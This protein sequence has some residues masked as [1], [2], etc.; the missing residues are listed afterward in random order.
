MRLQGRTAIVTGAG[1]G[2]GRAI[3]LRFAAEGA[4]VVVA[5]LVDAQGTAEDI[6]AKGL[7]ATFLRV[8]ISDEA[9]VA[10]LVAKTIERYGA[11]DILIN[12]AA[13]ASTLRPSPFEQQS[14]ADWRK[15]LDVNVLGLFLMCRAVSPH[16]RARKYGR[17]VNFSSGT[18]L[19]GAPGMMHYV[20]SKGAIGAMTLSLA[21]ELGADE[22]TVNAIAPGYL[23]SEGNLANDSTSGALREILA[24]RRAIQR[25]G[26]PEDVVSTALY[27]A[28]EDAGFVSAQMIAVNGG[29]P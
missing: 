1:T 6:R 26:L 11:I 22:I 8:D 2:L 20:A 18:T 16:M 13:I 21:N 7:E 25:D 4:N 29:L 9:A 15:V 24:K 12:N 5:D 27:L 3:A 17:I 14:L 10:D 23:L 19:R 28:S